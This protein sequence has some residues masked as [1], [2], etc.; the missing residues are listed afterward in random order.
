MTWSNSWAGPGGNVTLHN[1]ATPLDAAPDAFPTS[2]PAAY[3]AA[4]PRPLGVFPLPRNWR[5][6]RL[7]LAASAGWRRPAGSSRQ[8]T[9]GPRGATSSGEDH[10]GRLCHQRRV[11]TIVA[12][13]PPQGPVR[14]LGRSA[15]QEAR[16]QDQRH[17]CGDGTPP[18]RDRQAIVQGGMESIGKGGNLG[19][20]SSVQSTCRRGHLVEYLRGWPTR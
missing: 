13:D 11:V 10:M 1:R 19:F 8:S 15:G 14:E 3:A 4:H 17:R 9:L 7:K 5:F 6:R 18:P 12:V 2:T 16:D 20:W